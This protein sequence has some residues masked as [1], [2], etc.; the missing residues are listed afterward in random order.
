MPEETS[1]GALREL[2]TR[3]SASTTANRSVSLSQDGS[4]PN[5]ES[6]HL[7]WGERGWALKRGLWGMGVCRTQPGHSNAAIR[8]TIHPLI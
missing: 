2:A 8:Q 5:S 3:L 4:L 1:P 7:R 6:A